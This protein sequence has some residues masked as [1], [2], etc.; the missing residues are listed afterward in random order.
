MR[1]NIGP[2]KARSNKDEAG[3]DRLA[4]DSRGVNTRRARRQSGES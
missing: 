4:K 3:V 1:V 2:K